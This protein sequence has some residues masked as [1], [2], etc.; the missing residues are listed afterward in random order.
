VI[1]VKKN[2][3]NMLFKSL[4]ARNFSSYKNKTSPI[5][6]QDLYS[7]QISHCISKH[8]GPTNLSLYIHFQ[9]KYLI[10][11]PCKISIKSYWSTK[12]GIL[13]TT[14]LLLACSPTCCIFLISPCNLTNIGYEIFPAFF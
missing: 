11:Q 5:G 3:C 7:K 8:D 13:Y 9:N 6:L 10:R 2:T 1:K 4:V 12:R 14:L